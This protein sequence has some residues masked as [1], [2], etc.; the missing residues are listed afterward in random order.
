MIRALDKNMSHRILTPLVII[1]LF[2][3]FITVGAY[4]IQS[5]EKEIVS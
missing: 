1:A 4:D 5:Q 2:S 3:F